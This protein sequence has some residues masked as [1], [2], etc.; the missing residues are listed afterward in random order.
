MGIFMSYKIQ[1]RILLCTFLLL[2]MLLMAMFLIY[3]SFKLFQMSFYNW[4]GVLPDKQFVG[5]TNYVYAFTDSEGFPMLVHNIPYIITGFLQ[6]I[7]GLILAV[8]LISKLKGRNIF[9]SILFFPYII[10]SVAVAFMFNYMYDFTR[11]PINLAL[12]AIGLSPVEFIGTP[13]LVNISL[14]AISLWRYLGFTVVIY[15]AALQSVPREMYEAAEIDGANSAQTL[16]YITLPSIKSIVEL[17]L[18]LSLSGALNAFIE[19]LVIT[20]G[21][22]GSSSRTFVYTIVVNAFQTNRFSFAA[23]LSIILI[24]I[25]LLVTGIQRKV[26]LRDK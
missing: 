13:R 3:P 11:S 7:I 12:Q 16:R 19:T 26:V 8:I 10:N 15:I 23:A 20:H 6:N 9:R 21:G 17:N 5:F 4:D 2:P 1:K 18:F 24:A 22:P 14:A 25:I